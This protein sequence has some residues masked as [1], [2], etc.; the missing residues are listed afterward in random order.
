MQAFI[1]LKAHMLNYDARK[2]RVCCWQVF[3]MGVW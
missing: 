1:P 3:R 2:I